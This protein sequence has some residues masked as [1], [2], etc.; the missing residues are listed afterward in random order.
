MIKI[1][2]SPNC[3]SCRKVRK[4]FEDQK[5]PY[6]GKDIF[7]KALT[8]KDILEILA[9]SEDGSDDIISQRS[10]IVSEQKPNFDDMTVSQLIEFIRENPSI[11]KRPIIVDDHRIQVGY[12]PE[13]IRTFIP[14]ERRR[15]VKISEFCE[16][17]C[18]E[19]ED[20]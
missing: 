17:D 20:K 12:N 6:E 3:S 16:C 14:S 7:G 15:H 1:Y 13:E 2:Y 18:G 19:D 4:W 5:I 8:K 9:K 11:L 10:K